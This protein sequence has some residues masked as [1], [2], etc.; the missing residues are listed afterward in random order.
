[1]EAHLFYEGGEYGPAL[2]SLDMDARRAALASLALPAN[3]DALSA[4]LRAMGQG[5]GRSFALICDMLA[6]M[7]EATAVLYADRVRDLLTVRQ[8][9]AVADL[10]A[11]G[12]GVGP[13]KVE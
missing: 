2:R 6:D 1:M 10:L 4:R 12:G 5:G 8:A 11:A 13:V 9:A 7:P 3:S